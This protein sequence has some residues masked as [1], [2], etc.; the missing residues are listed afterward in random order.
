MQLS[1]EVNE[2]MYNGNYLGFGTYL[3]YFSR[4]LANPAWISWKGR[5]MF[6][7]N[8]EMT[9]EEKEI[10]Q[11]MNLVLTNLAQGQQLANISIWELAKYLHA[12]PDEYPYVI[13]RPLQDYYGC[14]GDY[15]NAAYYFS[16]AWESYSKAYFT[17]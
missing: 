16:L 10:R 17:D 11:Y 14:Y 12:N 15:E 6:L 3:A 13:S 2:G 9:E 4:I 5:Y 8:K 7:M 1:F